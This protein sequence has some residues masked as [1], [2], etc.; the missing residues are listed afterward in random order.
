[1]SFSQV[2]ARAI[3]CERCGAQVPASVL[4][5]PACHALMHGN[6][7]KTLAARADAATAAEELTAAIAAWRE[8][9]QLLPPETQ[10]YRTVS[11]RIDDLSRR[12]DRGEGKKASG[13][14]APP[15]TPPPLP[16][17]AA[18]PGQAPAASKTRKSALWTGA[19]VVLG[20]LL[21][22]KAIPILILSK[23]KFVLL[24]LSKSFGTIFTMAA[25][26]ALYWS[27]WGW[28]FAAG[29]V[30][31]IYI[32]EMGHVYAL[33]R[34]GIPASA[35]M[36]IPGLGAFIRLKYYPTDPVG[37]ARTGLAGPLWGLG[38]AVAAFLLHL[39]TGWAS[40]AAIAQVGA[41]INLFNLTPIYP[42]DGGHGFRALVRWQR[43][44]VA[45]AMLAAWAAGPLFGHPGHGLLLIIAI[46]AFAVSFKKN[47]PDRPDHRTLYQFLFL[48]AALGACL[49]IRV[50]TGSV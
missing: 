3:S 2:E 34:F 13:A 1:M 37:D 5:C 8:A 46:I 36:F 22:F 29:L 47:V 30:L 18:K 14:F 17:A 32:H 6:E 12:I 31:S 9:Q 49:W 41:W 15:P 48:I 50:P 4:V 35:P 45:G 16:A 33:R 7:L 43:F 28:K 27:L 26:M 25:S 21:K 38:A 23:M 20:V 39:S 19:V 11:Q 44:V 24:G 10:Q 42:L 40:L